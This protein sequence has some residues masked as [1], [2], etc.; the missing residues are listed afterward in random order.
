MTVTLSLC[1]CVLHTKLFPMCKWAR[2]VWLKPQSKLRLKIFSCVR[3]S[4]YWLRKLVLPKFKAKTPLH[5]RIRG[6]RLRVKS[7]TLSPTGAFPVALPQ[8][9]RNCRPSQSTSLI[10]S[11]LYT[12]VTVW[13]ESKSCREER[14]KTWAWL[15]M[16]RK[17]IW[18]VHP[19]LF[20]WRCP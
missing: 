10:S 8:D 2:C 14:G 20:I 6:I 13:R 7:R 4:C 11:D 17:H 15:T 3:Q 18:H 9:H 1:F 16:C 12:W 19:D 5:L